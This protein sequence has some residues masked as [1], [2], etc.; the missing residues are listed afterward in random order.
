MMASN[1]VQRLQEGVKI[2]H[3]F[4]AVAG[5]F[6]EYTAR[7]FIPSVSEVLELLVSQNKPPNRIDV[8]RTFITR[9]LQLRF[10]FGSTV[11][12]LLIKVHFNGCSDVR[13]HRPLTA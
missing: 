1:S 2:S 7:C 8:K 6:V 10:D 12:R 3:Y 13:R 5:D 11:V 9:W 4:V